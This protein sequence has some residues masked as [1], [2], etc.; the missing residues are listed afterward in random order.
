VVGQ[1]EG[2]LK[3]VSQMSLWYSCQ[4]PVPNSPPS[5]SVTVLTLS[6]EPLATGAR[7]EVGAGAG[8]D[9]DPGMQAEKVLLLSD[10]ITSCSEGSTTPSSVGP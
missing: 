4:L 8:A 9:L 10:A 6:L 1:S 3:I 5:M 2:L 7:A